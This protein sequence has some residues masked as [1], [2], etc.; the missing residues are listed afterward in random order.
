LPRLIGL[1]K[2]LGYEFIEVFT[3]LLDLPEGLLQCFVDHQ[4]RIATSAYSNSSSVHDEI[5]NRLG[6]FD[7]TMR[8]IDRIL[9]AGLSLRVGVTRMLQNRDGVEHTISFLRRK[10]VQQV[11]CD[12]MRGFGRALRGNDTPKLQ[13]LCGK[14]AG[15]TLCVSPEGAVSPCIMSKAW[16][17]GSILDAPLRELVRS[18]RLRDLRR[19]IHS[20]TIASTEQGQVPSPNNCEP[21]LCNPQC[22]PWCGPSCPPLCNPSA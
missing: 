19:E 5:T 17:V 6:S 12:E 7:R 9:A 10:G 1:A 20:Q 4:V 16:S 3:N 22:L 18:T 11:G 21:S 14:C 8:N 15:A 2:S 13:S